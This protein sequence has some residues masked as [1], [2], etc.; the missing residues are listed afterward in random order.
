MSEKFTSCRFLFEKSVSLKSGLTFGLSSL[1][2]FHTSTPCW[3]IL[4]C[5]ALAISKELSIFEA[6]KLN[7]TE[8]E[9]HQLLQEREILVTLLDFHVK[10]RE[11]IG[12]T[13]REFEDYVN[14]VLDRFLEIK[15]LLEETENTEEES[16]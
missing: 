5:S 16:W 2:L 15:K 13:A 6:N 3:S 4:K 7:V 9:R 8:Q 1:H 14:A 12:M 10:H 11:R